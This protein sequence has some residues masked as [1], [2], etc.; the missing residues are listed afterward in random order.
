M[1]FMDGKRRMRAMGFSLVEVVV[2][3]AVIG[4]LVAMVVPAIGNARDSAKRMLCLGNLRQTGTAAHVYAND[5]RGNAVDASPP[6][7]PLE[8]ALEGGY[9]PSLF[10]RRSSTNGLDLKTSYR[11]YISNF[12]VWQCSS[13]GNDR[14]LELTID[15]IATP[16]VYSTYFYYPGRRVYPNFRKTGWTT[17]KG[18]YEKLVNNHGTQVMMQDRLIQVHDTTS[19][20]VFNHGTNTAANM[21]TLRE[22]LGINILRVDGSGKWMNVSDLTVVGYGTVYTDTRIYSVLPDDSL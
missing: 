19:T 22:T 20:Y 8:N 15:P 4:V 11:D 7:P 21:G 18:V 3:I 10:F 6:P 1:N 14:N 16:I 9:Q 13:Q 2:V 5:N 12:K 17:T